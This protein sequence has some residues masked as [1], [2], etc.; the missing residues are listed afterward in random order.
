MDLSRTISKI[1][2]DF[3]W[4]R[5]IIPTPVY[6]A[7]PLKGFLWELSIGA[8]GQ[9]T[10]ILGYQTKKEVWRY[11]QPSGYNASMWWTD[12]WT[13]TGQQQ[14]PCLCIASPG[15]NWTFLVPARPGLPGLRTATWVRLLVF[16]VLAANS[17]QFCNF[18][19]RFFNGYIICHCEVK[20]TLFYSMW[21]LYDVNKYVSKQAADIY[22]SCKLPKKLLQQYTSYILL[23]W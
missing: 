13:D 20:G 10:R 16:F 18:N 23:A 7:P 21:T 4:K 14:R 9:K 5:Q 2:G 1:D 19:Y 3:S 22:F 8:W 6:F 17:K 15:I 11:L 12:R